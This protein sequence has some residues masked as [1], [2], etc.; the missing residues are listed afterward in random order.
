MNQL[1]SCANDCYIKIYYQDT[2]SIYWNYGVDKVVERY[3][4]N[5]NQQLVG[6]HLGNFHVDLSMDGVVSELYGIERLFLGKNTYIDISEPTDKDGNTINSG[7]IRCRG[8]P[9]PLFYRI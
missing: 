3:D 6:E 4:Q 9:T 1:L 5:H 8:I 2:D 7:H